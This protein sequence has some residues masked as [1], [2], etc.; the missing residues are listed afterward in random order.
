MDKCMTIKCPFFR[1]RA[2]DSLEFIVSI[3]NFVLLTRH[4]SIPIAFNTEVTTSAVGTIKLTNQTV[5][6]IARC[7]L[8][9]WRGKN[10][11]GFDGKGYYITGALTKSIYRDDCYFD[12]PDPDMPVSGLQ[13]YLLSVSN[14]F[15]RR[16]SR[17]DITRPVVVNEVDR[18]IQVFWRLEGVLNLPWHPSMKPWTGN[19]K[20][21]VDS[22]GLV[23]RHVEQWDV[24]VLDAFLSTLLPGLGYGAPPAPSVREYSETF[25]KE[26]T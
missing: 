5:A 13:K 16:K 26:I 11:N 3:I 21:H 10:P 19:T 4:K 17:A 7:I 6:E 2:I 25:F 8:N 9:D 24:S 18:T 15:D 20:Y 1:R 14:L 23:E 12:G 22:N